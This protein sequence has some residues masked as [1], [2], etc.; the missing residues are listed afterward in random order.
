MC[1]VKVRITLLLLY[2]ARRVA[3]L[4]PQATTR[5]MCFSVH[6]RCF[7]CF[8]EEDM[9][10]FGIYASHFVHRTQQ[11]HIYCANIHVTP[12]HPIDAPHAL[13]SECLSNTFF[14]QAHALRY[15]NNRR[16]SRLR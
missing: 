9:V 4:L 3:V 8:E 6:M 11:T 15:L 2:F 5:K 14:L 7:L 13:D 1:H 16:A 10:V 12:M